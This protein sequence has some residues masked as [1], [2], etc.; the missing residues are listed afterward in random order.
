VKY[1]L[2]YQPSAAEELEQAIEWSF[3]KYPGDAHAWCNEFLTAIEALALD[4]DRHPL[5]REDGRFTQTIRQLLF[6][7]GR[8]VYR[9]L[10]TVDGDVV[11]I[12]HIRFPGQPLL[13]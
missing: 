12:L 5:A 2:V 10:Y 13:R 1:Q 3:E 9:V 7:R 6:G 4:P 11:R 8:S